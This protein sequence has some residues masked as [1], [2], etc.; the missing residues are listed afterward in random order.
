MRLSRRTA[1][2]NCVVIACTRG[3][4]N[5]AA[6]LLLRAARAYTTV[7]HRCRPPP[8][9]LQLIKFTAQ[10]IFCPKL[11]ERAKAGESLKSMATPSSFS[12]RRGLEPPSDCSVMVS[13]RPPYRITHVTPGWC[14]LTQFTSHE[15]RSRFA[16]SSPSAWPPR[17]HHPHPQLHRWSA[18]PWR[19]SRA[20]RRARARG[21][22][23]SSP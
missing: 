22:R 4:Q 21:R 23:S 11:A 18:A 12:R 10:G 15:V 16:Q 6:A 7:P 14:E 3:S 17:P 5:C 19:A 20:R 1:R 2:T 13:A 9:N 8:P